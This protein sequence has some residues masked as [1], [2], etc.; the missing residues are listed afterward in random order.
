MS[1]SKNLTLREPTRSRNPVFLAFVAEREPQPSA[2]R[3][4]AAHN[5]AV[6]PDRAHRSAIEPARSRHQRRR[7]IGSE[8]GM[9]Q[10]TSLLHGSGGWRA[11][12][13]GVDGLSR[14]VAERHPDARVIVPPR[15]GAVSSK[16]AETAPTQRDQ[17][18][19]PIAE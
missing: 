18:L 4:A 2:E 9:C 16:T 19:Q 11:G 3:G 15:S 6:A 14:S 12:I 10:V 17:H 13:A 1:N 5:T 7:R 8:S